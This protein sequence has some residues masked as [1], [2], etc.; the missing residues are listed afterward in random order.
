MESRSPC[1]CLL[2]FGRSRSS[3][4]LTAPAA[5]QKVIPDSYIIVLNENM[6]TLSPS[7][8]EATATTFKAKFDALAKNHNDR[9]GGPVPIIYREFSLALF[10][11]YATL[12]T[13]TLKHVRDLTQPYYYNDLSGAGAP[14]YIL[15][16]GILTTH[17]RLEGRATLGENFVTG[18]LNID[19][20]GHGTRLAGL[21]GGKTYGV[22]KKANLVGV[23]ILSGTGS[24]ITSKIVGGID[25]VAARVVPGKPVVNMSLGGGKSKVID[26]TAA[27]LYAKNAHLF[28]TVG[29]PG[30]A[31]AEFPSG[32][33][34]TFAVGA[35]DS[36]DALPSFSAYG[37][38]VKMLT[39][40]VG[41]KSTWIGSNSAPSI[42]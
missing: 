26:S 14:A 21:I 20:N 28:V 2:H 35:T 9:N 1:H 19:D 37:P 30:D 32:P 15:D 22:A 40:G 34:T 17:E 4:P 41:I 6:H 24:G 23:K 12:D 33:P 10:G 18:G 7:G 3:H 38:C 16:T 36:N 8:S 27:R 25:W 31:C 11:F 5:N 29:S 42:I 39:P 13:T